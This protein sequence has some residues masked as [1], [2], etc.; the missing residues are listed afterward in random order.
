MSQRTRTARASSQKAAKAIAAACASLDGSHNEETSRGA[1]SDADTEPTDSPAAARAAAVNKIKASRLQKREAVANSSPG[2]EEPPPLGSSDGSDEEPHS[3]TIPE[4]SEGLA[5]E[6]PEAGAESAEADSQAGS[7]VAVMLK[8]SKLRKAD[9]TA[10]GSN[11]GTGEGTLAARVTQPWPQQPQIC[12]A[13]V[14][15][16]CV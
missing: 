16:R 12:L 9:G 11:A 1:D 8:S 7:P 3:A 13:I 4:D 6:E 14:M 15:R 5:G 10:V 2:P